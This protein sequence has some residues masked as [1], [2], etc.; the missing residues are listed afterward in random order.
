[1]K[2]TRLADRLTANQIEAKNV[3]ER[4][5]SEMKRDMGDSHISFQRSRRIKNKTSVKLKRSKEKRLASIRREPAEPEELYSEDSLEI[6]ELLQQRQ[7]EKSQKHQKIFS[8]IM[9]GVLIAGC[10]YVSILIYGVMV[11]DYNYNENGEIVPEV[12]SVQDIKEE[13]A[14][15]TILY[16]YLQCR[17][18]YEEVLMLDY[19]LGKGEEDPLTLAPLYEEKLDTV[20]SLSIKTDALTVETK[21]S[22]VKDML[23]SW[24]KNDIAV[25]LQNMSSAISQNNSETAQ[26]ALQDKD[27]VYSD[28]SLITQNLV[29]MGENLQGVDLTDVKQWTPEW[30]VIMGSDKSFDTLLNKYNILLA[31]TRDLKEQLKNS[32]EKNQQLLSKFDVVE[33]NVRELCEDILAKDPKEMKLGIEYSWDKIEL[34]ELIR[35]SKSAF[36]VYISARKDILE[37]MADLCEE[38]GNQIESLKLQIQKLLEEPTARTLTMEELEKRCNEVKEKEE[39]MTKLSPKMQE[40]VASGKI[41][42]IETEANDPVINEEM[43]VVVDA[44]DMEDELIRKKLMSSS[45]PG[46]D[47]RRTFQAAKSK[48]K[49][50]ANKYALEDYDDTLK[51]LSDEDKMLIRIIGTKGYSLYSDIYTEISKEMPEITNGKTRSSLKFLVGCQ[52]LQEEKVKV[53][54]TIS[55][56]YFSIKGSRI[57]EIL[58]QEKPIMSMAEKL[59]AEHDNLVHGYG[60]F[61]TAEILKENERF[62]N[63]NI[64]NRKHPLKIREGMSYIPDIICTTLDGKQMYIEYECGNHTQTNFNGKCNKMLNFTNT[65]NFIVPNRKGEEIINSQ[66]RKWIDNKGIEALNYVKIRVTSAAIIKD[67]NLL[68]DSSWH[69][70]YNLSKRE[71]PEVN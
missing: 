46:T 31:Q 64:W 69:F 37:R 20:S 32:Q 14:Y 55:F 16:Q 15:D 27:R 34:L 13:K 41:E 3:E 33:K 1:M 10:V 67:V 43:D 63:V 12:V 26:N 71:I 4:N 65:L 68:E 42:L 70:V 44:E 59:I 18:L 17:S 50:R 9:S 47:H 29:A 58:F 19:R 45:I 11:T 56:F 8:N 49:E 28:F 23:L 30:R 25:Y 7:E 40:K 39:M 2:Q 24:I 57:F 36:H 61:L 6:N 66:V 60:I 54:T 48:R 51:Q 21:Y 22:K 53:K 35:K 5:L 52:I 38:R 62:R